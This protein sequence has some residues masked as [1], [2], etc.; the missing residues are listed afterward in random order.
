[1]RWHEGNEHETYHFSF[2]ISFLHERGSCLV[3]TPERS[4]CYTH[5]RVTYTCEC[6]T[7]TRTNLTVTARHLHTPKVL[8]CYYFQESNFMG[9]LRALNRVCNIISKSAFIERAASHYITSALRFISVCLRACVLHLCL[10]LSRNVLAK[11]H[12]IPSNLHIL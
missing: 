9:H 12:E 4:N 2:Y 6:A 3:H 11:F 5:A 8:L 7:H 1:M 10:S